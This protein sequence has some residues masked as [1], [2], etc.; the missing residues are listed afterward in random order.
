MNRLF[1]LVENQYQE[2]SFRLQTLERYESEQNDNQLKLED[3]AMLMATVTAEGS[4]AT[5]SVP[6]VAE[7][8]FSDFIEDLQ[9]SWVYKRNCGFRESGFSMSTRSMFASRWS[10]LSDLSMADVSVLSVL[11]LPITQS[12]VFNTHRSSQ[13]WSKEHLNP[14]SP[15]RYSDDGMNLSSVASDRSEAKVDF[16]RGCGGEIG[17]GRAL[18][19]GK[20]FQVTLDTESTK[21]NR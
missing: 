17:E 18:K 16:C 4:N 9:Q 6:K 14:A 19:I 5:N 8:G 2:M 15:L 20:Y 3:D 1:T 12:E 21:M 13:T 11:N 10:C 7:E